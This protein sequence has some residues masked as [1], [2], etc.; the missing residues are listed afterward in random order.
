MDLKG[1]TD[2]LTVNG[3]Q[4]DDAITVTSAAVTV[5]P[6]IGGPFETVNYTNTEDLRVLSLAGNDTVTVTPNTT[7]TTNQQARVEVQR[8]GLRLTRVASGAMSVD[9]SITWASNATLQAVAT[10]VAALGNG[11]SGRVA[12]QRWC[13]GRST[14]WSFVRM[15]F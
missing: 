12:P 4:G 1:G 14:G 13:R 5:N 11:W 9:T 15:K 2:Q 7:T 10:A 3:T 8:D 6:T